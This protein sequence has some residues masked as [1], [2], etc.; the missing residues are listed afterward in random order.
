[1]EKLNFRSGQSLIEVIIA[2]TVAVITILSA[3]TV[4]SLILRIGNQDETYQ[5]AIFLGEKTLE[6]VAVLAGGSWQDL[7][8]ASSELDYHI[9]ASNANGDFVLETGVASDTFSGVV[10]S[11]YLRV[12]P[13]Q[14]DNNGALVASG[15]TDDPSTKKIEVYINWNFRGDEVNLV[16]PR[17]L[18]R[19]GNFSLRQVDWS[20]GATDPF[21][22][23]LS[24]P[25]NRFLRASSTLEVVERIGFLKLK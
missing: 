7:A 12:F 18:T 3:V 14:R 6:Q 17:Y 5:S 11:Y 2:T 20:A 23:V 10:Y 4:L 15:G 16:L 13:V 25:D 24:R 19:A 22:P 21:D 8:V 9:V 1:M